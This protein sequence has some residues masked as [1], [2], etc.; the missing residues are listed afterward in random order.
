MTSNSSTADGERSTADMTRRTLLAGTAAAGLL[1]ACG[2]QESSGRSSGGDDAVIGGVPTEVTV[3]DAESDRSTQRAA[4]EAPTLTGVAFVDEEFDGQ[5]LRAIDTIFSGGADFG[6]AWITARLIP[7]G[8]REAWYARWRDLADRIEEAADRSL[9]EEHVVSAREGF[10]RAATYH[11]TSGIFMYSAP[12]DDRFV[13]AH[14][15]Q[16]EAFRKASL[17]MDETFRPATIA[18]DGH[19]LDAYLATPV[20]DGPFP[21][22]IMVGGYDGTME[23]TYFAGGAAALRRGYAI[24]LMDGPG[25]G[26]ALIEQGLPFR[27]DWESVVS[28]QVDWLT[29]QPEVDVAQIVAMGRSWG[30]YLAPRAATAEKRLAAVIA[31]APQ[32]TPGA[33]ASILLPPEYRDQL[34]TGDPEELNDALYARM[35]ESR[36]IEFIL[37]RGMLAHGRATPVEYLRDLEPYTLDGIATQITCPVLLT[38]GENDAR[39]SGAQRLYDALRSPKEHLRFANA[40]GA[41]EHDEVGASALFSQQAFDWLDSTLRR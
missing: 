30:G 22:I 25:Q 11:R 33:N 32:Y 31:D 18:V 24:L 39:A 12:L 40:D 6:E 4:D 3:T 9:A 20:G 5:F 10:S 21:T 35:S 7:D 27:P 17:L 19:D 26:G 15:R 16:K 1:S 28:A 2:D 34:A 8:D 13:S 29:E 41:G 38:S 14:R 36:S 37:D 23:E